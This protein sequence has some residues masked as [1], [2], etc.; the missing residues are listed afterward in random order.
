MSSN[1]LSLFQVISDIILILDEYIEA[2]LIN[3]TDDN[4]NDNP[5]TSLL[6]NKSFINIMKQLYFTIDKYINDVNSHE[7]MRHYNN[8][9]IM[10]NNFIRHHLPIAK[11]LNSNYD[12]NIESLKSYNETLIDFSNLSL[13]PD[14]YQDSQIYTELN[15][16]NKYSSFDITLDK[17]GKG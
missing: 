1:A 5:Y 12:I 9:L 15:L 10:Y 8:I 3:D 14:F 4:I 17:T 13:F 6:N 16:L 2:N 7:T 11:Y